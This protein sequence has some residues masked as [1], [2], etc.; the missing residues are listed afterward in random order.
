[1]AA[2]KL[3]KKLPESKNKNIKNITDL[4]KIYKIEY[5]H[6]QL[7]MQF[8]K[9]T[10]CKMRQNGL[11]EIIS[12]NAIKFFIKNHLNEECYNA[13]TGDLCIKKNEK[14][15]KVECKCFT[16]DG[17]ISF[18]PQESW[19]KLFFLDAR[20]WLNN[21][22]KIIEINISNSNKKWTEI[23]FNKVKNE[24]FKTQIDA[25]R[26]PRMN[27][28]QLS[29]LIPKENKIELFNGSFEE[30][31]KYNIDDINEKLTKLKI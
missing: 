1:M 26:R 21:Q 2:N 5:N 7:I 30:M 20:K 11:C 31:I 8:N 25:G 3:T 16:S 23:V 12:E 9:E 10:N 15:T 28:N 14:I 19:D 4:I 6:N 29:S 17:P 18:G 13:S 27:W 24:T 22:F